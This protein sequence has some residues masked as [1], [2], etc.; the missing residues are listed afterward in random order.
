MR[1]SVLKL[2]GRTTTARQQGGKEHSARPCDCCPAEERRACTSRPPEWS[3][4]MILETRSCSCGFPCTL[5]RARP[6]VSLHK[7]ILNEW[8][9]SSHRFSLACPNLKW[10]SFTSNASASRVRALC[11]SGPNPNV[12]SSQH[13]PVSLLPV[14]PILPAERGGNS[15]P[16]MT[17]AG[18]SSSLPPPRSWSAQAPT[19]HTMYQ[20]ETA[21]FSYGSRG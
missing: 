15:A 13:L 10:F 4:G 19:W 20:V 6:A 1:P 12:P 8:A 5:Q 3:P 18:P 17:S 9:K 7:C 16:S 21:D 11:H 2:S 14:V